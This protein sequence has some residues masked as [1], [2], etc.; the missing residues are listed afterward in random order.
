[1]TAFNPRPLHVRQYPWLLILLLAAGCASPSTVQT[2]RA[3]RSV[4][5]AALSG[6]QRALVD[7]GQIRVGM[8]ED[9]VY[10]A[11]GQPAQVLRRGDASGEVVTWLYTDTAT[12][13]YH[14]WTYHETSRRDGGA[15]LDRSFQTDYGFHDYV[16]ASLEFSGGKLV[17][18]RMLPRPAQNDTYAT[19]PYGR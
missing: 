8:S 9:A 3:E 10:I 5:Y 12:D 13:A 18:W 11:W 7:Q 4:A 17:A 16:S 14:Y 2:R 1:M 19:E 6:E 15:F